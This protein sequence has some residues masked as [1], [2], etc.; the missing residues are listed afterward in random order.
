MNARNE[1]HVLVDR[2]SDEHVPTALTYLADLAQGRTDGG[3]GQLSPL[4]RALASAPLEDE[5][6]SDE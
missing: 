5:P 4:D 1:L 2:L 3:I 6:I